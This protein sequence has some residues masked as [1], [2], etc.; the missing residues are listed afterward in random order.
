MEANYVKVFTAN[1]D[2]VFKKELFQRKTH[3]D[4][5]F[6]IFKNNLFG[7]PVYVD[8]DKEIK[9]IYFY[10]IEKNKT[11]KQDMHCIDKVIIS[12]E[13]NRHEILLDKYFI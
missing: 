10:I 2:I 12:L 7:L 5:E 1:N 8:K 3:V 9:I 13:L 4:D 6:S 11:K